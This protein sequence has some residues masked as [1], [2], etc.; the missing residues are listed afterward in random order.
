MPQLDL[1]IFKYENLNFIISFF[2]FFFLNQ[3]VIFPAIVRNIV[4]RRKL[5]SRNISNDSD[6]F[7]S[8][9]FFKKFSLVKLDG[10]FFNV[11]VNFLRITVNNFYKV[12]STLSSFFLTFKKSYYI[13]SIID[14]CLKAKLLCWLGLLYTN[15]INYI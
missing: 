10:F 5:I 2:L 14:F 15:E 7:F 9:V 1:L 4:L 6:I 12:V 13:E 8:I 11:S 3:Y